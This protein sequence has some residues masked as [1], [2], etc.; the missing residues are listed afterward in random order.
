MK[1]RELVDEIFI[2]PRKLTNYALDPENP[3]GKNKALMFARH[4]G[5]TKNNY[6]LLLEQIDQKVLDAEAIA[7][8]QD[9]YGTRYQIDL[10]I[11]GIEAGQTETVRTAWLIP[12]NSKQARLVTIYIKRQP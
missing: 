10:D 1:L 2:D 7:Q 6:Q 11:Q 3:K 5:Y 4:L 9:Q 12:N 8:N